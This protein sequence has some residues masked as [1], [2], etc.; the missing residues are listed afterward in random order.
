MA[1]GPFLEDV[2][3]FHDA[4]WGEPVYWFTGG[5]KRSTPLTVA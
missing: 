2:V 5:G 4:V 3:D 1:P